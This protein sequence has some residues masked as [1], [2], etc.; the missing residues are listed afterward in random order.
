MGHIVASFSAD[1][2]AP[3]ERE[4]GHTGE[5]L[6]SAMSSSGLE[7]MW[8]QLQLDVS[9]SWSVWTVSSDCFSCFNEKG[10]EVISWK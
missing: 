3:V 1:G 6:V 5:R 4:I 9:V 10:S 8:T 7:G 2:N